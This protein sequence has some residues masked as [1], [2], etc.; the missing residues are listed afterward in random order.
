[1]STYVEW[2]S[3]ERVGTSLGSGDRKN[4]YVDLCGFMW[5]QVDLRGWPRSGP[6]ALMRVIG[7][8]ASQAP[9]YGFPKL[10]RTLTRFVVW[11]LMPVTDLGILIRSG[12]TA[13][14]KKEW[15]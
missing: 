2:L 3:V 6:G 5:I 4:N 7:C 10:R 13:R 12:G 11:V 8:L 1:M 15:W 9:P 14:W